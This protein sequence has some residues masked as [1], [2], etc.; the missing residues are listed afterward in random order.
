MIPDAFIELYYGKYQTVD[1]H[2]LT[3]EEAKASLIHFLGQ[4]EFDTRCVVVVH[5]YHAGQVLKNLVRKQFKH[6]IIESKVDLDAG[7]TIFLL[8]K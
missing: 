6:E 2:G 8:K 5:G 3:L 7:R 1:L 4:V